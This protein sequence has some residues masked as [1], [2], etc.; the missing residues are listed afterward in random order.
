MRIRALPRQLIFGVRRVPSTFAP[1]HS[2]RELHF[3]R[4]LTGLLAL[5]AFAFIPAAYAD[6]PTMRDY[7]GESI[8][9]AKVGDRAQIQTLEDNGIEILNCAHGPGPLDL[10]IHDDQLPLLQRLGI[11]FKVLQDDVN[12]WVA[13]ERAAPVVAGGDPFADFFLSYH[14]YGDFDTEGTILWYLAELVERYPD[15]ASLIEIGQTLEGRTIWGLRIANDVVAGEKPGVVFFSAEHAREWVTTMVP[16]YLANYLLESYPN[17]AEVRDLVDNL[18]IFLIPVF[19]VDGYIYSWT[20]DRFWRKNRRHHGGTVYGVDLNRNWGKGW[21]GPG[22]SG[23]ASSATYR[24]AEPFSEPETQVLRDFFLAHPNIRAQ[25]DIHSY[26]QLI[27]WSNAFSSTLSPEEAILDQIGSDMRAL[28]HGVHS[29]NYIAG[30]TYDTLYPASGVSF[31]WTYYE[32]GILSMTIECRDQGFYGFDL[33]ESQIIPQCEELLPALLYYANTPWVRDGAPL[34]AVA[35]AGSRY[36][37]I[38]AQD[39]PADVAFRVTSPDHPCLFEHASF[40]GYLGT[41]T[42]FL[43]GTTWGTVF[44]GDAEILPGS[45]YH[46][47]AVYDGIGPTRPVAVTTGMFADVHESFGAVNFRDLTEFVAAFRGDPISIPYESC[48]IVPAI[49][50]GVVSFSDITAAVDAFK[51]V[52][53]PIPAPCP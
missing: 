34:P 48:D 27:L 36:L 16:P 29:K 7:S 11:P 42:T 23:L 28:I 26:S 3:R 8:V 10:L 9:R 50:D 44:V 13:Q 49:P 20:T 2:R 45:T 1:G 12:A 6:R 19:N 41:T 53:H 17:S 52:P 14:E 46:V 47:Q 32:L 33:P 40:A 37:S 51:G 31:D 38:E 25:L 35:A 39:Y 5:A 30:P 18:E 43:P 15:F 24:G 4:R 22:A 21:G